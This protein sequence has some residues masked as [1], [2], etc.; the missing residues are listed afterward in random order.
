MPLRHR[1]DHTRPIWRSLR[2]VI[3]AAALF[4]LPVTA[5]ENAA[6]FSTHLPIATATVVPYYRLSVPLAAY[7]TSA[8]GDLRDLRV[9]NGAGKP[10]PYALLAASGST[11]ESVRRHELRWFPLS[12]PVTAQDGKTD[13]DGSL[14]VSIKQASD[15]TLVE[16][17]S[18]HTSSKP[19]PGQNKAPLRGYVLDASGIKD[20]HAVRALN[21]DWESAGGDFHL[22]DVETSDDLRRWRNLATG[23]QLARLDYGG[24]RIENRRID[25]HGFKD[26]YLRLVW[27]EPSAAPKLT[28]V[29]IEQNQSSYQSAPLA[30][31][32]PMHAGTS[33]PD[34]KPGEYRFRLAH[35][36]P[37][38]RLRLEL[39][40]GNQ[41]LP[42]EILSPR[43]ER[44]HWRN[45]ASTVVYRIT[46]KGRDWTNSEITLSGQPIQDF[47]L[48][49][50]PRLG[51]LA[52]PPPLAFA[53]QPAQIVFLASG[54]PPY[55]LA[56]G[57]KEAK[58]AALPP[59]TLVPGFG[60]PNSP[61]VADTSISETAATSLPSANTMSAARTSAPERNWKK[62][63]LWSVLVLG[64]LGM[65]AMAWQ[66]MKQMNRP[67][68]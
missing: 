37:I 45:L 56:V 57:N 6:S 41:L 54:E 28:R 52:E 3:G 24:A 8:H 34:L 43:R 53:L 49:I 33:D 10:V 5:Q 13:G 25:L 46:S 1:P 50:D 63:A 29:E 18:R 26:R 36:V 11:E 68:E 27:R 30:W 51:P 40:P 32:A 62:I 66:L 39:P 59:S 9:F 12:G 55:M 35:A 61:E 48:R 16:I 23:A 44:R 31:S 17:N 47:V 42:L 21:I 58:S 22:L 65:A 38:A 19:V 14:S 7:L 15:G 67:G 4:T 60:S 2:L 64:V 20:R